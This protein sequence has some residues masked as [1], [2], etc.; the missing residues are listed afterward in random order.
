MD[1]KQNPDG[2]AGVYS[3]LEGKT[4]WRVGGPKTPTTGSGNNFRAPYTIVIPFNTS[5][6]G[7]AALGSWQNTEPDPLLVKHTMIFISSDQNTTCN[8]SVGVNTTG[9]SFDNNLISGFSASGQAVGVYDNITDK[10]G[11]GKSRQLLPSNN[12]VV[13]STDSL[14]GI[15]SLRG[16]LYL[17]V[18]RV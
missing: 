16:S 13:I 8:I 2:S 18:I 4:V 7:T 9:V 14:G 6:Q 15:G 3:D 12:F 17:D 11:S 5:G 10:G 1:F